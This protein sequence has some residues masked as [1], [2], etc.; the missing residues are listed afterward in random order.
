MQT[1]V[2]SMSMQVN[3]RIISRISAIKLETFINTMQVIRR[4]ISSS[5]ENNLVLF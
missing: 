4:I 2:F 1:K 5:S 3:L